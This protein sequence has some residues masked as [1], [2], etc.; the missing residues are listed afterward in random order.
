MYLPCLKYL[1]PV[2]CSQHSAGHLETHSVEPDKNKCKILKMKQENVCTH[3][4]RM[5]TFP[6]TDARTQMLIKENL[7]NE[8]RRWET[9]QLKRNQGKDADKESQALQ[10]ESWVQT[11]AL[12][13]PVHCEQII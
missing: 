9:L 3:I 7:G 1:H 4:H 6:D 11:P 13:L 10:P 2:P 12:L 8:E 5:N